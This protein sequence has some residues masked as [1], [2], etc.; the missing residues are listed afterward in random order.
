M[1][2]ESVFMDVIKNSSTNSNLFLDSKTAKSVIKIVKDYSHLE[3]LLLEEQRLN[4][5]P[6]IHNDIWALYKKQLS[7]FWTV[8]EVKMDQ[9][10]NNFIQIKDKNIQHFIKNILAF[11]ATADGSVILNISTNFVNDIKN[12]EIQMCY[13]FQ[14]AMEGIH[15][16][17]YSVLIDEI[18]QDKDEKEQ[19]LNAVNTMP[20][21]KE[22]NAWGIK[23]AYS[24]APFIQR[25]VANA[26]VEGIFFS[27]S[28]CAIFW[29]KNMNIMPG[30]CQSNELISRDENMHCEMAYLIYNKLVNKM[31]DIEIKEMISDAIDIEKRFIND[32]LRCNLIGMNPKL[33][34]QYIEYVADVLLINLGHTKLYNSENPFAFMKDAFNLQIKNN[35]F[36]RKSTSY[37]RAKATTS[38]NKMSDD[39]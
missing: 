38:I 8:S 5:F 25:L 27:G 19:L 12:F 1:L 37:Q 2:S 15:S 26:I 24:G 17:M 9:D 20:C 11:F 21:I 6:I 3:P 14:V 36:E 32:S 7:A 18:V 23:W 13:N 22:K 35:F 4:A 16:E 33:M 39:F 29:L 30:L 31:S 34:S 28:F 10:R